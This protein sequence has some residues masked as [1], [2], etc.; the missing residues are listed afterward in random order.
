MQEVADVQDTAERSPL[1]RTGTGIGWIA[2]PEPAAEAPAELF[3]RPTAGK[4][5]NTVAAATTS[6]DSDRWPLDLRDRPV[7]T[8]G[9][10]A[11]ETFGARPNPNHRP[12]PIQPSRFEWPNRQTNG[13]SN[14][15]P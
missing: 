13:E 1:G 4:L 7:R 9:Q 2:Q 8:P 10:A 11:T 15:W 5:T 3:A 12:P 6:R 14:R